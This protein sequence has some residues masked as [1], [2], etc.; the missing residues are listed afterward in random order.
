MFTIDG[1]SES[2]YCFQ[3]TDVMMGDVL[4]IALT[5]VVVVVVV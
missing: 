2:N 3:M 1:R 4:K 5:C